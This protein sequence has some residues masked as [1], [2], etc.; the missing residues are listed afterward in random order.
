MEADVEILVVWLVLAALVGWIASSRGRNGF[1]WFGIS[2][3]LS[4]LLGLI[5]VLLSGTKTPAATVQAPVIGVAD[6]LTKLAA[7]RDNGTISSEEYESQRAR[8]LP[9]RAAVSV[10]QAPRGAHCGRCGKLLSPVWRDKCNH[11]KARYSDFP[12]VVGRN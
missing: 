5:G 12:P 6:E 2:L 1:V 7:L 8:L 9:A 11:C 10:S 3:L 4:P